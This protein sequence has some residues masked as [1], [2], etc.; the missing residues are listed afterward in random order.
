MEG[1]IVFDYASQYASARAELARWLSGGKIKRKET[2]IK[3]GLRNAEQALADLYK[4]VNTGSAPFHPGCQYR[5]FCRATVLTRDREITGPSIARG[6]GEWCRFHEIESVMDDT[7][8]LYPE[9]ELY[10][11][12][13]F[14]S[15]K[16]VSSVP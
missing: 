16:H 1:F 9:N 7:F 14:S 6:R 13:Q 4:G 15:Q 10:S 2:I 8:T 3:G 11:H 12:T 5:G